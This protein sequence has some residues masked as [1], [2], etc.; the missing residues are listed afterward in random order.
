MAEKIFGN[1]LESAECA[2]D[3]A[4]KLL[5][6]DPKRLERL[7][8]IEPQAAK[9]VEHFCDSSR[10]RLCLDPWDALVVYAQ[11]VKNLPAAKPGN[12]IDKNPGL[13]EEASA[14]ARH[15]KKL[16]P[17]HPGM[18]GKHAQTATPSM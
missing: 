12:D 11:V 18:T 6:M 16:T 3:F 1:N 2:E 17:A 4:T 13:L 15:Q 8:K 5:K 7:S 14:L 10:G 9:F